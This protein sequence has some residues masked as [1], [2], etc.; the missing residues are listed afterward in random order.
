MSTKLSKTGTKPHKTKAEKQDLTP[1]IKIGE[2]TSTSETKPDILELRSEGPQTFET[3]YSTCAYVWQKVNDKFEKRII[4]L[5]A[6]DSRNVSLLNGWN[7][8]AK[9]DNLK[10]GR[11]FKFK[12]WLGVSRN[13]RPIRR[14]RFV[15]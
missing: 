11:K 6:H 15:F 9:R 7:N 1:F 4:S 12:T 5:H 2:Y 14:W 3:E 13:N 10:K 8:A